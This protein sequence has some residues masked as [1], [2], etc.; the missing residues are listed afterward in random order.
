MAIP[1]TERMKQNLGKTAE[2][3]KI[4]IGAPFIWLKQAANDILHCPRLA[5]VFGLF[6]TAISYAAWNYLITSETLND[7]AAPLLAVMILVLGPISAIS[8]YEASRQLSSGQSPTIGSVLGAA[9]KAN[10]SCPSLFLSV[11]LVVL[12]IAWMMFSPLVYAIFNSGSL[13]IVSENQ[14]VI[15]SIIAEITSGENT[16][17]VFTYSLFTAFVGLIAFMISWFSFPMV[18]DKDCDPFTAIVTSLRAAISNLLVML[19]WVTIVLALVLAALVLTA[20]LYFFGLIFVVP[21]LAHATWHAYESMI[22]DLK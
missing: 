11:I 13:N 16:G 1:K 21:F 17:F 15:Q 20:D 19:I 2:I 22:G 5:I 6:F 14:T 18:L 9:F 7:V 4:D 12:S 3:K 10:G 8:L